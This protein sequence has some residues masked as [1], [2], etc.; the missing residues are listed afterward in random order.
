MSLQKSSDQAV[1]PPQP[2]TKMTHALRTGLLVLVGVI[3]IGIAVFFYQD[4]NIW[5]S[6]K[7]E[8]WQAVFLTNGQVYFGH[9]QNRMGQY[10]TLKNIYYLEIN[11]AAQ[12]QESASS[13]D[14]TSAQLTLI[15]LG[16][17]LHGPEDAMYIN[18]DQILFIEN[19][20]DTSKV[21][22]TIL[23]RGSQ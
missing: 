5:A 7:T 17:E 2:P 23:Q 10:V 22:Q 14:T 6:A 8:K 4:I 3:I 9:V 15:K 18:R 13:Q 11:K 1:V 12:L 20:K 16:Q 19:L 21:V